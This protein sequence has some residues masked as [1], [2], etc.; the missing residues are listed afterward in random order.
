MNKKTLEITKA[1]AIVWQNVDYLKDSKRVTDTDVARAL[2]RSKQT[3][4]NRR[5]HPRNTTL[6]DLI[7]LG[8][9]FEVEPASL[10]MPFIPQVPPRIDDENDD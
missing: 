8:R 2:N 9:Y 10:L 4:V 5:S 1:C 7:K 3:V 6:E